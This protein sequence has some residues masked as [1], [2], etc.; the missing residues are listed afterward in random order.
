MELEE[1]N[2]GTEEAGTNENYFSEDFAEDFERYSV[3]PSQTSF[4]KH[5]YLT[6]LNS[7]FTSQQHFIADGTTKKTMLSSK[8]P[9][10]IISKFHPDLCL[11]AV[12]LEIFKET[13]VS[14]VEEADVALEL[15]TTGILT[16]RASN[17]QLPQCIIHRPI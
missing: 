5:S 8:A 9:L 13:I 1:D 6:N 16:S 3:F 10:A 14:L 7:Y 12:I 15:I 17:K 4:F 2:N 11:T